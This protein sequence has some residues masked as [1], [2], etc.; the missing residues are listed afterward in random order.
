MKLVQN[1]IE[2]KQMVK[3]L[4]GDPHTVAASLPSLQVVDG[5]I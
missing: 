5:M 4:S 3:F 1:L 2:K